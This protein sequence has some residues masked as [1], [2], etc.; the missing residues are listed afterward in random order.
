MKSTPDDHSDESEPVGASPPSGAGSSPVAGER[1]SDAGEI[2]AMASPLPEEGVEGSADL[3]LADAHPPSDPDHG[4]IDDPAHDP[5]HDDHHSYDYQRDHGYDP[6]Y[7]YYHDDPSHWEQGYAVPEEGGVIDIKVFLDNAERFR[8]FIIKSCAALVIGMAICLVGGNRVIQLL[9]WPLRSVSEGV[10]HS[11]A[12]V[13]LKLSSKNVSQLHLSTNEFDAL[14]P[15]TERMVE[16]RLTSVPAGTNEVL[17]FEAVPVEEGL[18]GKALV[19]LHVY[20]P[21]AAFWVALQVAFYG[22]FTVAS[23]LIFFFL[24][25]FLMPFLGGEFVDVRKALGRWVTTAALLF[26]GGML[27]CY[28]L[29]LRVSLYGSVGFAQWMTFTADE[30]SATDY[31]SFVCK[32][33]LAMGLGFQLPVVILL[34]VRVGILSCEKLA[35]FRPYWVVLSLAGSAFITPDGSPVTM[36]LMA[37]PLWVLYEISVFIAWR[38]SRR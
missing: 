36:L 22:G 29:L 30:W 4:Q 10:G 12:M 13:F 18:K 26:F 17:G 34:L 6:D 33:T 24:G 9:E 14:F 25:Q 37:A 28:L 21:M 38:W 23:P 31:I 20:D 11:D 3:A 32:F 15:G 7:D 2:D 5:H 35:K 1:S 27:F 8:W 16:L 19:D